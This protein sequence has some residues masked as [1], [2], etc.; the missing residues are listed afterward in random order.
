MV[1]L[2]VGEKETFASWGLKGLA[3]GVGLASSVCV[4][5]RNP[6][7]SPEDAQ[8][9]GHVNVEDIDHNMFLTMLSPMS[10]SI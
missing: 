1:E 7:R 8:L 9:I 3:N 2:W 5:G 4:Q 10:Q 6:R